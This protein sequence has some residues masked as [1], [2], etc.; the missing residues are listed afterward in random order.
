MVEPVLAAR[1]LARRFGG[2]A[3]VDG[4]SLDLAPN[5]I[6]AVIGPN[7]AGKTTLVNLLSGELKPSAGSVMFEDIEIAGMNPARIA[8]L[9]IAR[10]Y[11]R[12]NIFA[13]FS[14]FENCRLAA[15]A[16]RGGLWHG[17]RS[18]GAERDLDEA[19][20]HALRLVGL[21]M[22]GRIAGHLSHGEQRQLEIAMTLAITP[23]V[24]LL[25]EPLSGMGAAESRRMT[26]LIK[27]LAKDR[28]ILLVE[29]DMDAVFSIADRL[30]VMVEGKVLETGKPGQI[31][32]SRAVRKAYLGGRA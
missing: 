14:A 29:H 2:L 16:R 1:G 18:A 12:V 10:S 13:G 7:G 28:A 31:R 11:Q 26:R 5:R 8:R 22:G 3:A 20:R 23:K 9:G 4:V 15:Q 17:L 19:A 6:H 24:L 32:K 27:R 30:T 21:G 25:D